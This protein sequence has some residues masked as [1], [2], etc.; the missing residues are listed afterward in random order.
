M[1][2]S[3]R[4]KIW[5][6]F[7]VVFTL[8][9]VTGVAL[10]GVYRSRAAARGRSEEDRKRGDEAHFNKM[11]QDL[12]LTDEQATK[13]RGVLDETRNEY[14]QLRTELRPRFD[15]PRLKARARIREL[16]DDSQ[17]KKFDSITAQM[18]ARRDEH[19]QQQQQQR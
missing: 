3:T 17:R 6:V 18:D 4:I 12:N 19:E 5:L 7:V 1:I 2:G 16:L 10:D 15:E 11:R 14:R 13:I 8:G 9:C